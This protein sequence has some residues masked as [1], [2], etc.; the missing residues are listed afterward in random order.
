M[1]VQVIDK[2]NDFREQEI[3]YNFTILV[4]PLEFHNLSMTTA[5]TIN[6][7]SHFN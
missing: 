1:R 3:L 7:S 4:D 2:T 5:L 6:K